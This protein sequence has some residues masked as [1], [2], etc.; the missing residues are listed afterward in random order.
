MYKQ[1]HYY[2]QS[3]HALNPNKIHRSYMPEVYTS[4]QI[5]ETALLRG[6]LIETFHTNTPNMDDSSTQLCLTL[7][8]CSREHYS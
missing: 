4:L 5:T 6:S 3:A 8:N 1:Y 7:Q 2:T